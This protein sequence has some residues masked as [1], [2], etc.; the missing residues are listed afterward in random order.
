MN[1]KMASGN[2]STNLLAV[3]QGQVGVTERDNQ[4]RRH[5]RHNQDKRDNRLF[6]EAAL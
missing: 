5:K 1:F 3:R 4:Y 2:A 6:V